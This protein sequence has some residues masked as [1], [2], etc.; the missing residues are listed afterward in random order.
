MKFLFELKNSDKSVSRN[1]WFYYLKFALAIKFYILFPFIIF[2][3][4]KIDSSLIQYIL[5]IVCPPYISLPVLLTSL[6]PR[7]PPP[8][9]YFQKRTGLQEMTT[10]PGKTR[11]R[12][13]R[14][15]PHI[16]AG[17]KQPN[18]RKRVQR[19][20]KRVRDTQASTDKSSTKTTS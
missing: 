14:Q 11:Y 3:K 17:Q 2:F 9:S 10:K 1:C 8:P 18:R 20:G 13:T 5:T 7:S 12:L 19:A 15:N 16:E 4:L 6:L